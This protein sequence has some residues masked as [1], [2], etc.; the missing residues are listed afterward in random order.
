M[1]ACCLTHIRRWKEAGEPWG[2]RMSAKAAPMRKFAPR[3]PHHYSIGASGK[4][5]GLW[6]GWGYSDKHV[7]DIFCSLVWP[8]YFGIHC[9]SLN[10]EAGYW[11]VLPEPIRLQCIKEETMI[12]QKTAR[13]AHIPFTAS[14]PQA[15]NNTAF[16][17][18]RDWKCPAP[19][20]EGTTRTSA[21]SSGKAR[22]ALSPPASSSSAASLLPLLLSLVT[23]PLAKPQ[24]HKLF[25][26]QLLLN[27]RFCCWT[28]AVG[29]IAMAMAIKNDHH[30]CYNWPTLDCLVQTAL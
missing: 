5:I 25:P 12:V 1:S 6:V 30:W 7:R 9:G 3:D 18:F 4:V 8:R 14:W 13:G 11:E 19:V 21:C 28:V 10:D 15:W 29:N 22:D 16:M 23:R 24:S 27:L 17:A 20:T 26:V 2:G